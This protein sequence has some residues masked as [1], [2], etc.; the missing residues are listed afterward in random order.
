MAESTNGAP[1]CRGRR[2]RIPSLI[3]HKGSIDR[4]DCCLK[5]NYGRGPKFIGMSV[6]NFDRLPLVLY[7][8]DSLDK[9][10]NGRSQR[11]DRDDILIR[12]AELPF[13]SRL[14]PGRDGQYRR[15]G[16]RVLLRGR[17][18]LCRRS[19]HPTRNHRRR[20]ALAVSL[21]AAGHSR[22]VGNFW[23]RRIVSGTGGHGGIDLA[24]AGL[25]RHGGARRL[26]G[27]T[28]A[29]LT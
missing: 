24:V 21:G 11:R 15:G 3:R 8:V 6:I 5:P 1:N 2:E 20:S 4:S 13:L 25:D 16:R 10:K 22:R 9:A 27:C 12:C 18:R 7:G 17:R 26:E 28:S 29:C 14:V 19:F 23:D